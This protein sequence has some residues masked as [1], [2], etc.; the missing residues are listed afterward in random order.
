M[1]VRQLMTSGTER[2]WLLLVSLCCS[3][4]LWATLRS[5]R[6]TKNRMKG[7]ETWKLKGRYDANFDNVIPS[8]KP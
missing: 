6:S 4:V 8:S 1:D 5:S 2:R 7:R 3:K